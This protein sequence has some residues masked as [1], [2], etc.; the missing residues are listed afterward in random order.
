MSGRALLDDCVHCGFCLPACPTYRSWAQEMDSP[1][2]RI[3][4]MR[5]LAEGSIALD[6][7]VVKHFDRCLGCMGCVPAC[8]SGVKYDVLIE[9]TRARIES[10]YRRPL[11]DRLHRAMVFAL[12]P[13]PRRLK[14]T[15]PFLLAYAKSGLQS[16]VRK[17]GLA[18]LLPARL[19]QL[20][21]LLPDVERRHL[22]ATL[23]ELVPAAGPRRARVGLL[24]G[25][26]QRVF[27]PEVN[28]AT[29]RVLAA[30]GCEV[31]IPRAQGC[32]GAL[33][34]HAGREKES[35]RMA[36]KL[37]KAFPPGLDAIL[38]NAAGCGSHLKDYGRL[39]AGEPG[40]AKP[41]AAFAAK[42]KDVTE[43][44]ASLGPA[45]KRSP[46]EVRVAYHDACHLAH[47][48]GI[49]EAPRRLLASIPGLT[50]LEIPDG[51]QCCGS[52]GVYNL[53]EPASANEIGARKVENVLSTK[54][55][56]LASANPG[57]TLQIRKILA[58]RGLSIAAAHP[59]EILAASIE[60][61]PIS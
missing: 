38:V 1:R 39:F 22:R 41:A 36:R 8:P 18:R 34:V 40:L 5:G 57:C 45:A 54:P 56:L 13:H 2:G 61:R 28:E 30:E 32:C 48:Q 37:M 20:E 42:V 19:A 21:A 49:R 51:D 35:K 6:A 43:F 14:A 26:V 24:A 47:A 44:L 11:L 55:D 52:A 46:L 27:F 3:D 25:C 58:E 60:G 16:L 33:S 29:V 17:G 53:M 15:L 10:G 50:L 12:F 31:V 4:L 7:S 23:P 9:E 59:M